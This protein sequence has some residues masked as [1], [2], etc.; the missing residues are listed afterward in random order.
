MYAIN[1]YLFDAS[2]DLVD[3]YSEE[4]HEILKQY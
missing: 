4:H 1:L 2:L 3:K